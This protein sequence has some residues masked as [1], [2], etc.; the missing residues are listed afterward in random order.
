MK[1]VEVIQRLVWDR[2]LP[3]EV[4]DLDM[5]RPGVEYVGQEYHA[6]GTTTF[7]FRNNGNI[8]NIDIDE[9]SRSKT[10]QAL[11]PNG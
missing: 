10:I 9:S 8:I 7:V 1:R 5:P 2:P 4:V 6:D 11:G 3:I